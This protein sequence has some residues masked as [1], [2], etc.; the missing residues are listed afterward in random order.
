MDAQLAANRMTALCS[1]YRIDVADDVCDGD[2]GRGKLLDVS[3]FLLPVP[4][5]VSNL[6]SIFLKRFV[7]FG[8]V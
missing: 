4:D 2:V 1:L 7:L 6:T 5:Q 8:N 3:L